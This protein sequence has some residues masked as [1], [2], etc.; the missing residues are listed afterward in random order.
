MLLNLLNSKTVNPLSA[1]RLP[2]EIIA[3]AGTETAE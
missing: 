2:E 3:E 1:R